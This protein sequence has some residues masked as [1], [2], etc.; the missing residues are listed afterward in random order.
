MILEIKRILKPGGKF[1][2]IEHVAA[3][4][5][6]FLRSAQNIFNPINRVIADGCNCNRETWSSIQHAGFSHVEL[7]HTRLGGTMLVHSP[8]IFGYAVK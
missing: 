3:P 5:G 4:H 7:S 2:F 1:Y 8:H 6:S